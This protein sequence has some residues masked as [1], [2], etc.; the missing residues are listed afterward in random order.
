MALTLQ[1]S[2]EYWILTCSCG[3]PGCAAITQGVHVFWD[4]SQ[5]QWVMLQPGPA[6][7]I[8]FDDVA[9]RKA[10][11]QG[12]TEFLNRCRE[13]PS[14]GIVPGLNYPLLQRTADLDKLLREG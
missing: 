6:R 7:A 1:G 9:Y 2:G 5:V 14:E 3:H 13:H 10:I 8:V 11:K 12:L 4:G